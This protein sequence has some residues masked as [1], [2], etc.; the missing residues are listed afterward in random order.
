MSRGA[1]DALTL[2]M[3]FHGRYAPP[4]VL[5][6]QG[7]LVTAVEQERKRYFERVLDFRRVELQCD[8]FGHQA[9]DRCD[10][11]AG[12]G[13]HRRQITDDGHRLWRNTDLLVRFSQ[14]GLHDVPIVILEAAARKADLPRVVLEIGG[15]LGK[16]HGQPGESLDHGNQHSGG[17]QCPEEPLAN[18]RRPVLAT[19][20]HYDIEGVLGCARSGESLLQQRRR[21][22]VGSLQNR[23]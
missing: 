18:E 21:E 22:F 9:H 6:L 13:R 12:H 11:I 3:K 10:R 14:G 23:R 7:A 1:P 8:L 4:Q 15:T 20:R 5:T 19:R 16:Q 2:V 17:S